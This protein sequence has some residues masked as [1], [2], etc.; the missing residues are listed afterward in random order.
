M[1]LDR[2]KIFNRSIFTIS[3]LRISRNSITTNILLFKFEL[4]FS[5]QDSIRRLILRLKYPTDRRSN[6]SIKKKKKINST[7]YLALMYFA[8]YSKFIPRVVEEDSRKEADK[9]SIFPVEG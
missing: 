7:N 5:L 4:F 2:A 1:T 8:L 3:L 6:S 9:I